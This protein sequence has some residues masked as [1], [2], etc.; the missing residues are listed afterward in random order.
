MVKP[1]ALHT[2]HELAGHAATAVSDHT[3]LEAAHGG[4]EA[5]GFKSG[6]TL[7]GLPELGLMLG[8]V[9]LFLQ[10]LYIF[11]PKQLSLRRRTHF[12]KRVYIITYN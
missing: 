4:H 2:A 3:T 6:D 8:F 1:G 7:P 11:F 10:P 9:A 5:S 12:Y